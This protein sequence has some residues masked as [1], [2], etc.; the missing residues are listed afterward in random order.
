MCTVCD[1]GTTNRSAISFLYKETEAEYARRNK[2]KR[3]FGFEIDDEEIVPIYDVPHLLK[4]IRNLL[5]DNVI[6]YTWRNGENKTAQWKYIRR[7]YELED[8]AMEYR[9][10]HKLTEA[11]IENTKKMKVS[12]AAQVLSCRVAAAIKVVSKLGKINYYII[13]L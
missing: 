5:F 3:T 8:S 9:L 1:Q 11:H 6:T 2:E 4:C 10:C 13:L 7:I 12:V